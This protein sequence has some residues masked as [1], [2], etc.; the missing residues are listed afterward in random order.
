[1]TGVVGLV[2]AVAGTGLLVWLRFRPASHP[3]SIRNVK[4][5]HHE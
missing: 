3:R 1:V 2:L 5:R 4:R